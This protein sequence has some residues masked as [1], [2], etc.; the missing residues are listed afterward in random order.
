[1]DM[2]HARWLNRRPGLAYRQRL[3]C[4]PC[5]SGGVSSFLP[6]QPL[7]G[8]EIEV[9][10]VQLPGRGPRLLEPSIRSFEELIARLSSLVAF[11]VARTLQLQGLPAPRGLLVSGCEAPHSASPRWRLHELDDSALI[12]AM[13]EFDGTLPEVLQE[14]ELMQFLL[15]S[16]R[17]DFELFA[18]YRYR[19]SRLSKC[20]SRCL[21]DCRTTKWH[22]RTCHAGAADAC[23]PQ[24]ALA[25]GGHFFI[26]AQREA[27]L[28]IAR[29]LMLT[30]PS[31]LRSRNTTM[32]LGPNSTHLDASD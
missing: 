6:W 25:A 29:R 32:Q 31:D 17:A 23:R 2:T 28:H 7:L 5:A 26:D 27:V 16:M 18:N 1:M 8:N 20:R 12:E 24:C 14:R 10:A 15:P 22:A 3:F 11:E 4:F 21:R 19:P 9:C 13:R 30:R